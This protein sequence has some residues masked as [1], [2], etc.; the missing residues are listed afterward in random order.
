MAFRQSLKEFCVS[1]GYVVKFIVSGWHLVDSIDC[2]LW[3][4]DKGTDS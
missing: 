2:I 1:R 4:N 3:P